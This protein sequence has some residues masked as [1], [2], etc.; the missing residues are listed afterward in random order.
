M[1]GA[2]GF[3]AAP[4]CAGRQ[5]PCVRR[6]HAEGIAGTAATRLVADCASQGLRER[7]R[8]QRR[9]DLDVGV[10]EPAGEGFQ[11]T[12]EAHVPIHRWGRPRGAAV[13]DLERDQQLVPLRHGHGAFDQFLVGTALLFEPTH[14]RVRAVPEVTEQ[15]RAVVGQG[16]LTHWRRLI[17]ER[18][19]ARLVTTPAQPASRRS[20]SPRSSSANEVE[21]ARSTAVP[22]RRA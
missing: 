1:D 8:T 16:P 19:R 20:C 6:P 17:A 7:R 3:V 22:V 15:A 14:L 10:S 13:V 9:N 11:L 4:A 2:I 21:R 5:W 18:S 12:Y